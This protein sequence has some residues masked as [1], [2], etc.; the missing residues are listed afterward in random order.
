ML[1]FVGDAPR[2]IGTEALY[3]CVKALEQAGLPKEVKRDYFRDVESD[4]PNEAA[5]KIA[6]SILDAI[7]LAERKNIDQI[8]PQAVGAYIAQADKAMGALT[9][10]RNGRSRERAAR[11][12]ME[13]RCSYQ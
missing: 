10:G 8:P 5:V 3:Y 2:N 4:V 6:C 1:K 11:L 13:M 7:E 12:L 9:T